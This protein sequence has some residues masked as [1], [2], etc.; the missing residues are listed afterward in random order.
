M[1]LGYVKVG[2]GAKKPKG[3][4]RGRYCVLQSGPDYSDPTVYHHKRITIMVLYEQ[5]Q[6]QE[7]KQAGA[8]LCQA[9]LRLG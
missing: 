7:E 2:M 4:F 5:V 1:P 3:S 9:Q 6:E 8:E